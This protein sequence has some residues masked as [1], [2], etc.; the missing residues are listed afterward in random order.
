MD[1]YLIPSRRALVVEE[2]TFGADHTAA[3]L[4]CAAWS[5]ADGWWSSAVLAKQLCAEPALAV[6][7]TREAAAANYPGVLPSEDHLRGYFTDPL[8]L[9]VAPPLRLRPDA[10]PIYRVLFAGDAAGAPT[11]VGDEHHSVELRELHTLHAWAVDVTVLS[12]HAPP[13]GPVLRQVIQAMR[14][15][16]FLPV[17]V[18]L[19]G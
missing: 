1:Y 11:V 19:L 17:T 4:D 6:A 15:N 18:E 12:P 7:V 13:V 9:S 16:G 14:H 3:A 8:P 2:F 10:P 5:A